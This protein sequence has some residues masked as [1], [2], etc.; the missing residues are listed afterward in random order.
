L[1]VI[2]LAG[3]FA[4]FLVSAAA[5]LGGS[6]V[7]VPVLI[8]ALDTKTGIA[9]AAILLAG[10]NV[11]K[12]IAYRKTIALRP[13]ALV[14]ALTMLG[15]AAG[16]YL[17]LSIPPV[18]VDIVVITCI[19]FTV[20]M[21]RTSGLQINRLVAPLLAFGGGL[22]SGFSG[23]SG[24]MKGLALRAL[25]LERFYLV[26][27]ASCVSLAGDLTKSMIFW[28][29]SLL[30]GRHGQ[31]LLLCLPLMPLA[32]YLGRF[33]NRRVGERAYAILFWGVMAGYAT[34]LVLN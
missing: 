14:I 29:S 32:T 2:A 13:V 4:A 26:G 11:F 18:A 30:N 1:E 19:V 5:G 23:T 27:A 24:P 15:A 25:S 16:A 9:L 31:F 28:E 7:L 34:R 3:A 22:F 6:L 12:I 33:V 17:L 10:N 8:L 21:E 20:L